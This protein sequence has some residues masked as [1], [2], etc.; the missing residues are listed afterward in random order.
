MGGVWWFFTLIIIS[1]YTA[2]LAAFLTVERM[3]TPINSADEL[4]NQ[5]EISYGTRESG[6]TNQFFNVRRL[7]FEGLNFVKKTRCVSEFPH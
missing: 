7:C 5:K 6:S 1:S 4:P 3:V 2:N